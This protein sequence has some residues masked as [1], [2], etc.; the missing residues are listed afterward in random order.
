MTQ[1]YPF[2]QL[3]DSTDPIQLSVLHT[4]WFSMSLKFQIKDS[5]TGL[6]QTRTAPQSTGQGRGI[7]QEQ[8]SPS[9]KRFIFTYLNI[10]AVIYKRLDHVAYSLKNLA[11]GSL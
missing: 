6:M 2:L 8:V 5:P 7:R 4:L 10:V 3:I 11:L 1:L 9:G